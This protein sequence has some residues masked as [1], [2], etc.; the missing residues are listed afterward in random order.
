MDVSDD[1]LPPYYVIVKHPV[2][3]PPPEDMLKEVMNSRTKKIQDHYNHRRG[4]IEQERRIALEEIELEE[5]RE[6]EEFFKRASIAIERLEHEHDPSAQ[7]VG[8]IW[9]S[10]WKWIH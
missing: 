7:N 6:T 10:F 4:V 1:T 2:K 9:W 5:K 3:Q 8:R